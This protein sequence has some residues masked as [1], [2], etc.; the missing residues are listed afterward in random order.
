[1][2]I[3]K[4]VWS[5]LVALVA[6]GLVAPQQVAADIILHPLKGCIEFAGSGNV[7]PQDPTAQIHALNVNNFLTVAAATGDF[8]PFTNLQATPVTGPIRWSGSGS[9][10]V[11]LDAPNG[12]GP[13]WDVFGNNSLLIFQLNSLSFA[14]L[15]STN[16]TLIGMASAQILSPF[17][18]PTDEFDA[19]SGFTIQATGQDFS[20]TNLTVTFCTPEGGATTLGLLAVGLLSLVAVEGLRRK[21]EGRQNSYR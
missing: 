11:L 2:K 3:S 20:F 21:I 5:I 1:M 7:T 14:A 12:L 13:F 9:S 19:H 18:F 8:T 4:F 6:V 10:A 16:L 17:P 15:S